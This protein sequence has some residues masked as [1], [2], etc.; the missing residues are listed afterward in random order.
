M[1]LA[2]PL[3][4]VVFVAAATW[5]GSSLETLPALH[6]TIPAG[7]EVVQLQPSG[8]LVSLLGLIECPAIEGAHRTSEGLDGEIVSADG[9]PLRRFPQ[10]FS[11]RVT[12]S[13]RKTIIDSPTVSLSTEA[14]P[15]GMLLGLKF[16]LRGYNGL[17]A[18][19]IPVESV[20]MIGVPADVPYDERV[21]RVT[22]DVGDRPVTERF[23]L[24]VLS[25]DGERLARFHF[26]LL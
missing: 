10:H 3:Y 20:A 1:Y 6:S 25:P 9:M 12:A 14:D 24:E 8:V 13:L 26:E 22:F 21:Y 15:E 5:S 19:Q 17:Q 18:E 4:L 11:Y 23:V 16:R 7:Y 2:V